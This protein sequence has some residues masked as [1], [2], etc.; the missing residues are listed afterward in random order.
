MNEN[1]RKIIYITALWIIIIFQLQ[2]KKIKYLKFLILGYSIGKVRFKYLGLES[3]GLYEHKQKHRI[4][5][6]IMTEGKFLTI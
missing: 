1:Y 3:T 5:V 4:Y 6:V 2:G